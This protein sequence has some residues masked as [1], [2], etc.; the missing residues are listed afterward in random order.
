MANT[1]LPSLFEREPYSLEDAFRSFLRPLRWEGMAEVPQV[2]MDIT[3][4]EAAYT[5]KAEIPGVRKEDIRVE[6]DGVSIPRDQ[7]KTNGW[8][9]ID[10]AFGELAFFG[11]ACLKAQGSGLPSVVSGVVTCDTSDRQRTPKSA[12][13]AAPSVAW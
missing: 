1:R 4:A 12:K 6:I 2:K 5:V 9:W 8:D 7:T 11:D 13:E 3:E 10:Q